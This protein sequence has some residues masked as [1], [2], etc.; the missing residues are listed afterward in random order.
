M[1][2]NKRYHCDRFISCDSSGARSWGGHEARQ[3]L[4]AAREGDKN[5]NKL[6]G[7]IL[8]TPDLIPEDLISSSSNVYSTKG[9]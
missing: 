1:T 9:S 3:E 7:Q 6:G 2:S 8:H 5:T 4:P